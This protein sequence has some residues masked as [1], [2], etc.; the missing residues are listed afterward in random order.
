MNL[1][2]E[3]LNWYSR[4]A[5]K[6]PWRESVSPYSVWLSEVILQQTRVNQGLEYYLRFMQ[7]YP[8]VCAMAHAPEDEILK[9]WQGL[10]YY[11][12]ARNMHQT[13]KW[14]CFE[15][16]GRFPTSFC[17]LKKLKGVGEYTA[18]AISSICFQEAVPVLDGNVY[19]VLSRL[20]GVDEYIDTSTGKNV[21]TDLAGQ[22]VPIEQPGIYNQAIMEFGALYCTPVNPDCESCVF[23]SSCRAFATQQVSQLPRKKSK[24]AVK[25]LYHTY[26][27]VLDKGSTFVEK[28]PDTGIWGG[29]YQFPLI[30]TEE[31]LSPEELTAGMRKLGIIAQLSDI[32]MFPF[33]DRHLLSH[34]R[35]F[36]SY[37]IIRNRDELS[38]TSSEFTSIPV[39]ELHK[40]PV[41]KLIDRFLQNNYS[42]LIES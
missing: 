14:V 2:N 11:S 22:F 33:V 21:F 4:H 6:L 42:R 27:I 35:I 16:Q 19:R 28:R 25:D 36:A 5:R 26:I 37:V 18:A 1:T 24:T 12:R 15:N 20:F 29:L 38:P 40:L 9:L 32:E 41:S 7:H 8:D 13:A 17:E 31:K 39:V 10:G 3:L 34:R 30:E 23:R